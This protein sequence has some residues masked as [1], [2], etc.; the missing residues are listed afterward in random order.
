MPITLRASLTTND[1][2]IALDIDGTLLNSCGRVTD[3]TKEAVHRA[4]QAGAIILAYNGMT[5]LYGETE[6]FT[7]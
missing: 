1:T 7:T 4:A 6:G 3:K 2:L 5:L